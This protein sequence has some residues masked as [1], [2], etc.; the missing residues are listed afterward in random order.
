MRPGQVGML[1]AWREGAEI[2][3][4]IMQVNTEY[5]GLAVH[6]FGSG[7]TAGDSAFSAAMRQAAA[8]EVG[9][10]SEQKAPP[11]AEARRNAAREAHEALLQDLT[12]YL[13]TPLTVLLREAVMKE[14]GLSEEDLAAM[15]PSERLAAEATISQRMRERLLGRKEQGASD[16]PGVPF[17]PG[18]EVA[19]PGGPEFS[20][21]ALAMIMANSK[22]AST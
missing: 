19:T 6:G 21:A 20:A 17:R 7:K 2:E 13:E 15:K 9:E 4:A 11:T 5:P 14:L 12:D 8:A 10:A 22:P 16:E 18:E 1:S 3:G